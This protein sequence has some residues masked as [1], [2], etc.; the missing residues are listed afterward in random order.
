V[1][2]AAAAAIGR[3]ALSSVRSIYLGGLIER[4]DKVVLRIGV[5]SLLVLLVYAGGLVV[6][7]RLR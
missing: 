1:F 5:D 7:F 2:V 6:L 4:R 3:G